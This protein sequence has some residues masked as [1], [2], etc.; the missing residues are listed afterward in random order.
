MRRP[1]I[2]LVALVA[3]ACGEGFLPVT[4]VDDLRVLALRAEPPEIAWDREGFSTESEVSA[5]VADPVQLRIPEREVVVGYLACTPDPADPAPGPC[6]AVATLRAPAEIGRHLPDDL[7]QAA[8]GGPSGG[9]SPFSFL[10]A[11]RCRHEGGCAPLVLERDGLPLPLPAPVYRLEGDLG[12][13]TLPAGHPARTRGAQ[14]VILAF[15]VVASPGELFDGVEETDP[16]RLPAALMSRF[17]TLFESRPNVLALKR[18]QVRGPD[19]HDEANVNPRVAGILAGG[20]PLPAD[21]GDPW[22]DVATFSRGQAVRLFPRPAASAL[23]DEGKPLH[24]AERQR[25]TRYR[26]DG[27]AVGEDEEEWRFSWFS[28]GGRFEV[29]QTTREPVFWTAPTGEDDD[30][31]PPAGR[32]F[33][34]LVVRDGRGGTDWVMR[35]VRVR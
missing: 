9:K 22:P 30:P 19:N 14:V 12:L 34:Y 11:E 7:C 26:V 20:L 13:G 21:P 4:Y 29:P 31:V 10:G 33:L 8:P 32:T 24:G 16:C 17:F 6:T 27:S 2:S 1:W 28:T 35:E 18:I 25:Y 3:S 5:L 23:D 15:A